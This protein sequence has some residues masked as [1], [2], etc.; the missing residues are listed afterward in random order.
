M[1]TNLKVKVYYGR[2]DGKHDNSFDV[3]ED[4]TKNSAIFN[5]KSRNAGVVVI[6][7]YHSYNQ[8]NGPLRLKSW[9]MSEKKM[10]SLMAG[11]IINDPNTDGEWPGD[12]AGLFS[13]VVLDEAQLVKNMNAMVGTAIDWSAA[14]FYLLLTATPIYNSVMDFKGFERFIFPTQ[15]LWDDASLTAMG[16]ETDINPF[17]LPDGHPGQALMATTKATSKYI[18]HE[19]VPDALKGERLGKIWR[20]CLIRRTLSSTIPFDSDR[21]I[22]GDIPPCQYLVVDCQ[23]SPEELAVYKRLA[24]PNRQKL[25]IKKDGRIV[26]NMAKFRML[27]LGATWIYFPWVAGSVKA[28]HIPLAIDRAKNKEL[29]K[30]WASK[31]ISQERQALE[32][33]RAHVAEKGGRPEAFPDPPNF[34]PDADDANEMAILHILRG[35]PRYRSFLK[36]VAEQVLILEEKAL[37]FCSFP[38]DLVSVFALLRS[39]NIEAQVLHAKMSPAERESLIKQFTTANDECPV[40]ITTFALN[41]SGLNLQ[42]LCRNLHMLDTPTSE[43]TSAQA[44]GR[45]WRLGQQKIVKVYEYHVPDTFSSRQVLRNAAKAIPGLVAQLDKALYCINTDDEGNLVM[46]N[47]GE[48]AAGDLINW[49]KGEDPPLGTKLLSPDEVL[50]RIQRLIKDS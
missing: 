18:W 47:W 38:A 50:M 26:F 39:F 34:D 45:L 9:R 21:N 48:S 35:S 15:D 8:R 30:W 7:S 44:I 32:K 33:I 25:F 19:S 20:Q 27:S 31:A 37:V 46:E 11:A 13:V 3:I 10:T 41:S 6:T 16:L 12:L 4:L 17:E 2:K 1:S 43:S 24:E 22:G 14:P 49:S 29:F 5:G 40:L 42:T 23:F 36:R 28:K